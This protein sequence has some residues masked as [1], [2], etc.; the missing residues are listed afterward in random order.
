[1]PIKIGH[2]NGSGTQVAGATQVNKTAPAPKVQFRA[3]FSVVE[4]SNHSDGTCTLS[5]KATYDHTINSKNSLMPGANPKG[6]LLVE[7]GKPY[8]D[9]A[10]LGDSFY[11]VSA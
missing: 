8:S 11:L 1:M 9:L 6:E 7:V 3:K 5:L 2:D 10:L 4:I